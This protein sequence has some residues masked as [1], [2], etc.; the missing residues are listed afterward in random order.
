MSWEFTTK[1]YKSYVENV[2]PSLKYMY[3]LSKDS[4]GS[5]TPTLFHIICTKYETM[6]PVCP[7]LII[8]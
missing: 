5:R 3:I 8:I 7:Y 1:Q 4:I 6:D 2:T